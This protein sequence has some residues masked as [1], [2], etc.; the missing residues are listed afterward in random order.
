LSEF[1]D[2]YSFDEAEEAKMDV[3]LVVAQ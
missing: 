1:D 2:F 3:F